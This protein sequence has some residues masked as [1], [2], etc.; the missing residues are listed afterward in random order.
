MFPQDQMDWLV[1]DLEAS[2]DAKYTI[3]AQH[4]P[5]W[6]ETVAK[7]NPDPLHDVLVRYGV[8][9]VFTGHYHRYFS[10]EFD[11]VTYTGVGSSGGY[12][13]PGLTGLKYHF[14]WVTADME[15][16]SVAIVKMGS[17]LPWDEL[18]AE[19]FNLVEEI[20]SEAL[21]V[22]KIAVGT[23]TDIEED[24]FTVAVKNFSGD[25]TL[26]GT[27]EWEVAGTWR[28]S[29]KRLPVEVAPGESHV[30]R[31]TARTR[32]PLYPVPRVSM[33]YPYEAEKTIDIQAALGLARTAYARRTDLPIK[34]D[35][36]VNESAWRDPVRDLYTGESFTETADSTSF[37]FAWD[38]ANLYIGAICMETVMDSIAATSAEQDGAVYG[39]DCVGFFLQPDVPDG[40]LYQIYFNP[41]GTAFDQKIVVEEGRATDVDREWNGSY[42]VAVHRGP[43]YWSI[44]IGI[45]L[46]QLETE[47]QYEKTWAVNFRRKQKRLETSADWQVPI[48][49]DPVDYGYLVMQ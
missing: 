37:Y 48:S 6:I 23:A 19:T 35:G 25:S 18:P 39:E 8:D 30:A 13:E 9:A 21:L 28:V 38:D 14:M 27:L 42:D 31:F 3:V 41:L 44:E 16:I 7:G 34:V 26:T 5:F 1:S 11:G 46:A 49:Y 20:Q 32:G 2:R 47:A 45:P 10:G 15:G 17:I 40:P 43:D 36:Q 24:E 22:D 29:P 4:H 12:C 33:E